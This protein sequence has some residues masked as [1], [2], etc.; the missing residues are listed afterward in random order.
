MNEKDSFTTKEV[1]VDPGHDEEMTSTHS[2]YEEDRRRLIR[3]LYVPT[4][5]GNGC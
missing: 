2:D 3:R 1:D 4:L 5:I